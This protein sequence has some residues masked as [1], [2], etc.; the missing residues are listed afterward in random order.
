MTKLFHP[1]TGEALLLVRRSGLRLVTG[2]AWRA[3]IIVIL[4]TLAAWLAHKLDYSL[5]EAS[6]VALARL[7]SWSV[8]VGLVVAV[9]STSSSRRAALNLRAY[10]AQGWWA[11]APASASAEFATCAALVSLRLSMTVAGTAVLLLLLGVVAAEQQRVVQLMQVICVAAA[12][13]NGCGLI[14]ALRRRPWSHTLPPVR[15]VVPMWRMAV[16]DGRRLGALS[17]WQRRE[18]TSQWRQGGKFWVMGLVA[19]GIPGGAPILPIFG[20]VLLS[21]AMVWFSAILQAS[22][23]VS[24]RARWL[25]AAVPLRPSELTGALAR[26]PAL[27]GFVV[28]GACAV[29]FGAAWI[30]WFYAFV[31]LLV[32]SV[33]TLGAAWR[34]WRGSMLR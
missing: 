17:A 2:F 15:V 28:F 27:A 5:V 3:G 14:L 10:L 21:A 32:L 30:G 8:A 6:T 23:E 20:F 25:M 16:L 24:E 19:V 13:G 22:M 12:V 1:W 11:A 4:A 18:S 9:F 34:I 26:Y 7:Q 33:R 31:I 29:G